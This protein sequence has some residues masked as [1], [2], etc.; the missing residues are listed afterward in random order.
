MTPDQAFAAA[1]AIVWQDE[2][3]GTSITVVDNVLDPGG[4]TRGGV[5][6]NRHPEL[7][8]ESLDAM[9]IDDFQ[10]F[11][12]ANYWAPNNCDRLP[13]PVSM[14]VFDGEVN[15]GGEGAMALQAACGIKADGVIGPITLAAV[16]KFDPVDLALWTSVRR[17]GFYRAL[18]NFSTFGQGWVRRLMYNLYAAGQA[19][20]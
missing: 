16:A 11:Y 10:T 8:R 6:L 15:S 13:W 18:A 19:A 3:G 20:D 9:T 7:T 14:V 12:R 17:D 1:F 5:A 2:N 4:Y